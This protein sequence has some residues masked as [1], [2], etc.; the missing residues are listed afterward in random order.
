MSNRARDSLRDSMSL[1]ERLEEEEE[2][3]RE[4]KMREGED[5]KTNEFMS[6]VYE[7]D[8]FIWKVIIQ[9]LISINTHNNAPFYPKFKAVKACLHSLL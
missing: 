8:N 4:R 7:C 9:V 3:Q 5:D 1:V 6:L 2:G